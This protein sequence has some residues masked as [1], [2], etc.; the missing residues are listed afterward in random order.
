M[1]IVEKERVEPKLID[2]VFSILIYLFFGVMIF[3]SITKP[4]LAFLLGI[5][6]VLLGL[7]GIIFGRLY[8]IGVS[9]FPMIYWK[10]KHARFW[11]IIYF[12]LGLGISIYV[13]LK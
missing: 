8:S 2:R 12:I 7:Y 1:D 9:L 13:L 10:G 5:P 11:G 3:F 4:S 6:F